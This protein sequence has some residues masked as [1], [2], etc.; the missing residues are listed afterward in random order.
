MAASA[1]ASVTL[2]GIR[3]QAPGN[4]PLYR[5]S[6]HD[7]D[8]RLGLLGLEYQRRQDRRRLQ[9]PRGQAQQVV[10]GGITMAKFTMIPVLSGDSV[11]ETPVISTPR[12][13]APVVHRLVGQPPAPVESQCAQTQRGPYHQ[14]LQRPRGQR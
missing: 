3:G 7:A 1:A 5:P 6:L 2:S 14:H 9:S 12:R 11:E 10:Q 8:L 13:V 4:N